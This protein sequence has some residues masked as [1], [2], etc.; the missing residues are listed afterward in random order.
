MREQQIDEYIARKGYVPL[1]T[2]SVWQEVV[3]QILAMYGT[4]L[5]YRCISVAQQPDSIRRFFTVFPDHLTVP[6]RHIKYIELLLADSPLLQRFVEW[7]HARGIPTQR[8]WE[9]NEEAGELRIF[10]F[11]EA[12]NP[13]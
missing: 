8:V 4:N 11:A 1:A 3:E 12:P 13:Q 6:Y 5:H 7:L 2:D 9:D 10:G